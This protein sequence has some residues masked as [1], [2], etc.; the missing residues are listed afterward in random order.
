MLGALDKSR[1]KAIN[2][3]QAA[4]FWDVIDRCSLREL[5]FSGPSY[6]WVC[7]KKGLGVILERL[8]RALCNQGWLHL[9]P[10]SHVKHLLRTLS[11]H[12]PM[13]LSFDRPVNPQSSEKPFCILTAWFLHED[14][15]RLVEEHWSSDNVEFLPTMNS[16]LVAASTWNRGV[17][18]NIFWRKKRVLARLS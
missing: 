16:F 13:L 12:H 15:E 4:K 10:N 7:K 6:T 14:F 5:G 8:D 3:V 11:D 1:G 17:F 9:F 2:S 18:G